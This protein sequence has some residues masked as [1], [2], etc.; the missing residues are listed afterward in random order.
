HRPQDEFDAV[1]ALAG[2]PDQKILAKIKYFHPDGGMEA[3]STSTAIGTGRPYGS[4]F[5]KKLYDIDKSM[6]YNAQVGYLAIKYI[7]KFQ[8]DLTVGVDPDSSAS[9]FPKNFPQVWFVADDGTDYN[10][11]EKNKSL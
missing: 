4:V 2:V 7:E 6:G 8:L 5:E 9:H 1:M 10:L 11:H 3:V